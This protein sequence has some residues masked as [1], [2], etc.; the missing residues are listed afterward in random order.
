MVQRFELTL[1]QQ[2]KRVQRPRRPRNLRIPTRHHCFSRKR[3]LRFL[4][5]RCFKR[6][7]RHRIRTRGYQDVFAAKIHKSQP[8]DLTPP[9]EPTSSSPLPENVS[10][11]PLDAIAA[12]GLPSSWIPPEGT[13]FHPSFDA[14][15]LTSEQPQVNQDDTANTLHNNED[16][17]FISAPESDYSDCELEY[18]GDYENGRVYCPGRKYHFPIDKK[19]RE[20]AEFMMHLMWKKYSK[21]WQESLNIQ[22]IQN[23]LDIGPG[24]CYWA[25]DFAFENSQAIVIGVD[26]FP[27]KEKHDRNVQLIKEDVEEPWLAR[28]KYD[29]VHSRDMALAIRDWDKLLKRALRSLKP[30]GSIVVQE[31]YYSP[32]SEDGSVHSTA[33]PLADFFSKIAEGLKALRVD[34]HA[35]TLLAEKMRAAGFINV[36]TKKSYITISRDSAEET[37]MLMWEAIYDGLQGT[38]LG[39]LTRGLGWE[40]WHVEVY[41][42]GVRKCLRKNL[43]DTK[44]P[45]YTIHAQRP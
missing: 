4:S 37:E 2:T 12:E 36:T 11:T 16:E 33:Q 27:S 20:T 1:R 38:A 30:G 39:P 18:E 29:L 25:D 35:I 34:L 8:P 42:V 44:L 32:Q 43:Q 23:V 17:G 14:T 5:L 22:K 26:L 24:A 40:R 45:I 10:T 3:R 41:L 13:T 19:Q 7:S 6:T 21:V 9:N 31:I 28:D 15:S